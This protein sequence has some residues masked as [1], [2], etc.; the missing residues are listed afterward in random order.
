MGVGSLA[1]GLVF[2]Y[3]GAV[4]T[5]QGC[6]GLSIVTL[7]LYMI[8]V[9]CIRKGQRHSHAYAKGNACLTFHVP[10]YLARSILSGHCGMI[11]SFVVQPKQWATASAHTAIA[12]LESRKHIGFFFLSR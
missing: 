9:F 5:F 12:K 11:P 2:E 10:R 1:G 6:A 4:Y 7:V 8:A 3:Y